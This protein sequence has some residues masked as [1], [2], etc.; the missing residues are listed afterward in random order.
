VTVALPGDA[1][2][3]RPAIIVETDR[4]APTEHVII[5][6]G[7]SFLRHD[8]G[9]RRVHVEPDTVNGLRVATQFQ[10]DK[11]TVTRRSKCGGRIGRLSDDELARVNETLALVLGLAD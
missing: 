7:T 9:Q 1:G 10:V 3:P 6:P 11:V 8:V 5:C 4:L 2:K